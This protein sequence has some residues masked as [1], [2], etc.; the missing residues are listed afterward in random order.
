[1]CKIGDIILINNAKDNKGYVGQHPFIV[2]DD[3]GGTVRGL[4]EYDFIALLTSSMET[5][6]KIEKMRKYPGNLPLKKEDKTVFSPKINKDA[7]V[8]ADKFFYFH[9]EKISFSSYGQLNGDIYDL[10]IEF[11]Q[12]LSEQGIPISQIFSKAKKIEPTES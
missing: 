12:E 3:Q 10:L 4:Y 7:F 6:E 8:Q 9:K 11:I 2:I 1:M 5:D